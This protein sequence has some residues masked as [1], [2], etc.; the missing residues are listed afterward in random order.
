MIQFECIKNKEPFHGQAV[1][2]VPEAVSLKC[3]LMRKKDK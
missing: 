3:S 1:E 2:I